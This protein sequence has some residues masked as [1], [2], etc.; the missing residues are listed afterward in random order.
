MLGGTAAAVGTDMALGLTTPYTSG[1]DVRAAQ[2]LLVHNV[3]ERDFLLDEVDG[4]FGPIT[5]RGCKRAR[6]WLGFP[7]TA[8][9]D[10]F[11]GNLQALLRGEK[12]LPPVYKRRRSKRLRDEA[13]VAT[14]MATRAYERARSQLGVRETGPNRCKFTAW[15]GLTGPW[16]CMFVT[17]C[18]VQ[19]GA[20]KSFKRG[21]RWSYCFDVTA[22]A[23]RGA[24]HL[25][26]T[27]EPR[28]GDV[29][30]YGPPDYPKGHIGVFEGW[31]DQAAGTFSAIEGNT[32]NQVARR[33]QSRATVQAFV[34]V[35]G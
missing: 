28:R 27:E 13:G 9:V 19:A 5:A 2:E 14:S 26:P 20:T 15:Y 23:R 3:Y 8:L 22:A 30:V 32:S 6:F 10:V 31:L 16:C 12:P 7:D 4:F 11:D 17:W 24:F 18:Y 1:P 29:V 25:V 34:R 21:E 35:G 33:A